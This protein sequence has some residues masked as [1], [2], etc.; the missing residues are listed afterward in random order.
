[1]RLRAILLAVTILLLIM[2]SINTIRVSW[3][4]DHLG[5]LK[6]MIFHGLVMRKSGE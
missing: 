5:E 2:T 1:M 4:M 3:A 6:E